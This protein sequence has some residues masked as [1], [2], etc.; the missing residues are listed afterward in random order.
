MINWWNEKNKK[1]K[2]FEGRMDNF[3]SEIWE[4]E[5]LARNGDISTEESEKEIA[6]L[7]KRLDKNE[8]KYREYKDSDEYKLYTHSFIR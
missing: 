2:Y 7:Q 5:N 8:K 1:Q 3:K 4:S 6:K